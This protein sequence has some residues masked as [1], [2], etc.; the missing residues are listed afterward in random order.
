MCFVNFLFDLISVYLC[1]LFGIQVKMG[2]M[3]IAVEGT[4]QAS[5]EKVLLYLG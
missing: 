2:A 4:S 5:K 1:A 3:F